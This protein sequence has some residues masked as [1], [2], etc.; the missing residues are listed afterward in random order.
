MPAQSRRYRAHAVRPYDR[1]LMPQRKSNRAALVLAIA[2][3]SLMVAAATI[4]SRNPDPTTR[5]GRHLWAGALA[6]VAV[7]IVEVLI[8]AIPLRRGEL[9]AHWA[10]AIP[11]VVLGVP[12]FVLDATYGPR[13]TRMATLLPQAIPS[14][15]V[16]ILLS[17]SLRHS[18]RNREP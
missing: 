9:W 11:F 16:L 15:L 6:I 13:E 3:P 1:G 12:I 8:C 7:A 4:L 5:T 2:Y 17:L 10:A 18:L 14:L